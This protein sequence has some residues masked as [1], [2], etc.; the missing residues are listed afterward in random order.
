MVT[1]LP[2]LGGRVP[3]P[4]SLDGD[5][6]I[7]GLAAEWSKNGA[8]VDGPEVTDSQIGVNKK[9]ATSPP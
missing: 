7:A 8:F 2:V 6:S 4:V 9:K 1:R 3:W 5:L